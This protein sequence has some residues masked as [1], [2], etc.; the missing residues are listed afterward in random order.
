LYTE[1]GL[2]SPQLFAGFGVVGQYPAAGIA[3]QDDAAGGGGRAAAAADAVRRF[4]LPNDFVGVGSD[5]GE[6]AAHLG[7]D[8]RRLGPAVIALSFLIRIPE[9][10]KGT[11]PYRGGY[12]QIAGSGVVRHWRPVRP[13]DPRRLDQCRLFPENLED[14]ARSFI[15]FHR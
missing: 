10:R 7:A 11:G 5:R 14:A 9:P 4:L 12:V 15:S 2:E 3:S 6:C 13:T 8:R 1:P